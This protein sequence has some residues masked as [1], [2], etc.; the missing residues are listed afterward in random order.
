MRAVVLLSLATAALFACNRPSPE[1]CDKLCRRYNELHYWER[2]EKDAAGLAPSARDK[3][4]A[5]R[6][7][8]WDAI[9]AREFD[10]GRE[11]CVKQCRRAAKRDDVTCVEEAQTAAAAKEC[12]E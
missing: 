5:E 7:A 12:L 6:Q 9:A 4:R 1:Q 11:N 2:F 10:P 3:L 8:E